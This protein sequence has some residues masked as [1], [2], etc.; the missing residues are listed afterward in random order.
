VALEELLDG[1]V[2][3]AGRALEELIGIWRGLA[4]HEVLELQ[5]FARC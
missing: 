3:A 2:I 5:V 4:R 1:R